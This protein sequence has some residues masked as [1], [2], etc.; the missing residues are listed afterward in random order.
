MKKNVLVVEYDNSTIDL[1]H[2]ILAPPIFEIETASEGEKARDLVNSKNYDLVITAAMLPKFHGFNLSQYIGNKSPSTKIIIISGVYKGI[3]YK[4]Q[5][6]TQY[7][8]DD[9]VEKP[10]DKTT[11]QKKVLDLLDLREEDLKPDNAPPITQIPKSDT[12]KIPITGPPVPNQNRFSSSD[13]FGD[14]IEKVENVP[15][16]QPTAEKKETGNKPGGPAPRNDHKQKQI[17]HELDSLKQTK[18]ETPDQ[19]RFKKIEDDISRKLEDTLSGLGIKQKTPPKAEETGKKETA[20][21]SEKKPPPSPKPPKDESPV[22]KASDLGNYD[23][24]G[25]IARGGMAEIYKA[26]K[27]GIKGFEKVIAIKKILSGYGE[28]DKYIEMFVDEAKIAA[29]LSH[30]N[31]V[32]IHD[33]GKKD[34]YYF[35]AMEYVQG[36][37]LRLIFKKL[38]EQQK[39]IPEEISIYL[40][41]KVLEALGYAHSAKDNRGENLEIVHRDISPPNIMISFGG[42]IKLTDFGVSKA[43]I[44]IHQTI[45]GALKGKLLYM[46]PE[47]AKGDR[48][49]DYRADLYS[50]GVVLFEL[51]TGEKLFLAQSEMEVLKKVQSGKIVPP[52][53]IKKDIHPELEKILLKALNKDR[54][55]R[56]Q[57]AS[58]MINDLENYIHTQ[59]D[60]MPTSLHV[61]HFLYDLFKEEIEKENIKIDLKPLPYEI[62]PKPGTRPEKSKPEKKTEP[63]AEKP[64]KDTPPPEK[65]EKDGEKDQKIKGAGEKPEEKED[66]EFVPTIEID[67]EE[68]EPIKK[69]DRPSEEPPRTQPESISEEQKKS[70]DLPFIEYQDPDQDKDKKKKKKIFFTVLFLVF[71]GVAIGAYFFALNPSPQ[72][73]G[74][75]NKNKSMPATQSVLSPAEEDPQLVETPFEVNIPGEEIPPDSGT[76][77]SMENPNQG[78]PG[79]E[80][81]NPVTGD[82]T[83]PPPTPRAGEEKKNV[84][85][86]PM[87]TPSKKPP[88]VKSEPPETVE[89]DTGPAEKTPEQSEPKQ[90]KIKKEP[91]INPEKKAQPPPKRIFREGDVVAASLLDVK[92][93]AVST[94]LPR[95]DRKTRRALSSDQNLL[96]SILID[97][98]GHIERVK[99]LRKSNS[100]EINTLIISSIAKWKY[101]PA[102]KAQVKVKTWKQIPITIKKDKE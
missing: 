3:E 6:L 83:P 95:V 99:L 2:E 77:G 81:A 42:E 84:K 15:A 12:A 70:P 89:S 98:R 68:P 58:E 35:I 7:K 80:D 47:Q 5:A 96:V 41:I 26:K 49:I 97:H 78:T 45:S 21:T 62:T 40:I 25:L 90:E 29:E 33:L 71:A 94:P 87:E 66:D 27:K 53:E 57:S 39:W 28:D 43:A 24:L 8:A 63:E 52:S 54:D 11:F 44:K 73:A 10:L 82:D 46:S 38:K 79:R 100:A 51:I 76:G 32:Q 65:P 59:Y 61:V 31:I 16:Q 75:E 67:F 14:I 101:Q 72:T 30:P 56:Y 69:H 74:P 18:K 37:D 48:D 86:A 91:V 85:A 60:H 36:K 22:K 23:I 55:M 17:E 92:P 13:L 9:F 64:K 20:K 4:H 102:Q 1:I 88:A 19:K 50:A 34:D 93:V